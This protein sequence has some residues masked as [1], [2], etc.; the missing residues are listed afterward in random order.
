MSVKTQK[1][2]SLEPSLENNLYNKFKNCY[3]LGWHIRLMKKRHKNLQE[4]KQHT[5]IH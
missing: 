2:Y 3:L 4:I 1:Y 5:F